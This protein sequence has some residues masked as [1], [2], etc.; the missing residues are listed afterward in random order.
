MSL[1]PVPVQEDLKDEGVIIDENKDFRV[2]VMTGN[3]SKNKHTG[4]VKLSPVSVNGSFFY[5]SKTT[6]VIEDTIDNNIPF[7]KFKNRFVGSNSNYSNNSSSDSSGSISSNN[8]TI[9][10][11]RSNHNNS[12]HNH[13]HNSNNNNKI[14]FDINL[15]LLTI[16]IKNILESTEIQIQPYKSINSGTFSN[17]ISLSS[18]EN[19]IIKNSM[20]DNNNNNTIKMIEEMKKDN[21]D[22]NGNGN[23]NENDDKLDYILRIAKRL[24]GDELIEDLV[25]AEN[26]YYNYHKHDIQEEGEEEVV[27][28]M[29]KMDVCEFVEQV[30]AQ[31]L[32]VEKVDDYYDVNYDD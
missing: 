23:G 8:C 15:P 26:F 14:K 29:D 21:K 6:N 1:L 31:E 16:P 5:S 28:G 13:N 11:N 24:M 12:N 22:T 2:L 19:Q 4:R 9:S 7:K 10:S 17:I 3:N 18:L 25:N 20:D 27:K 30:V 32:T